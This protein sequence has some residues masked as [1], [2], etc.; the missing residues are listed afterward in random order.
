[1]AGLGTWFVLLMIVSGIS[2]L[3]QAPLPITLGSVGRLLLSFPL[4]Y[5][6]N[7]AGWMTAELH[8][9]WIHLR[10]HCEHHRC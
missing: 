4:P 6:A 7:T 9:P 2:A 5:I 1:M 10:P 3:A 8:A